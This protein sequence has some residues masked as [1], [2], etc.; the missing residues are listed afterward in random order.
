MKIY[1][2]KHT[3][4]RTHTHTHAHTHTTQR[5]MNGVVATTAGHSRSCEAEREYRLFYR[6]LLQKRPV[7]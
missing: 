6:S 3:H 5:H 4:A 7:I 2:M 1:E